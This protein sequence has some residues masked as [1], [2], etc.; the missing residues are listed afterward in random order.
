M[1]AVYFKILNQFFLSMLSLGSADDTLQMAKNGCKRCNTKHVKC[2]C[3][4][5]CGSSLCKTLE[6]F[7]LEDFW[8]ALTAD[9]RRQY[10][11]SLGII[12]EFK[13]GDSVEILTSKPRVQALQNGHGGWSER[14]KKVIYAHLSS[15]VWRKIHIVFM[16]QIENLYNRIFEHTYAF[17]TMKYYPYCIRSCVQQPNAVGDS[18][19]RITRKAD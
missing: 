9:Q 16:E 7:Q 2:L 5:I 4:R 1:T 15:Q 19:R 10:S 8:K 3:S 18:K 17:L 13:V 6:I 11:D 12:S 14:M